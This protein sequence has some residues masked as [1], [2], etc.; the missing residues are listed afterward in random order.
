MFHDQKNII[1]CCSHFFG[2]IRAFLLKIR[3][4]LTTIAV[5]IFIPMEYEKM[6]VFTSTPNNLSS[7]SL[8]LNGHKKKGEFQSACIFS[9]NLRYSKLI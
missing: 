2:F 9:M 6:S 4:L 3:F 1:R 7:E 5:F 8:N